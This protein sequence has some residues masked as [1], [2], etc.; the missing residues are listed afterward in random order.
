MEIGI[1]AFYDRYSTA[2]TATVTRGFAASTYT[3]NIVDAYTGKWDQRR[4]LSVPHT[5]RGSAAMTTHRYQQF[6]VHAP[7]YQSE[8][9]GPQPLSF[10]T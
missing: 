7:L 2:G 4:S 8:P 5:I 10:S 9:A 1:L 3:A 6:P